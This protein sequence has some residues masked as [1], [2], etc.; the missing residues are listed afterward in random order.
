MKRIISLQTSHYKAAIFQNCS[1]LCTFYGTESEGM[2]S[3]LHDR[4]RVNKILFIVHKI[5]Q[6]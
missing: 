1:M 2:N 4:K 5:I 6:I 3:I